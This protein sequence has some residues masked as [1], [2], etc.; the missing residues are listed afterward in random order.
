[1]AERS[2]ANSLGCLR[3]F[4][5]VIVC[6]FPLSIVADPRGFAVTNPRFRP[7]FLIHNIKMEMRRD[8]SFLTCSF[9]A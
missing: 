8:R 5:E 9:E 3:V 6:T 1:M 4:D 2:A 7:F